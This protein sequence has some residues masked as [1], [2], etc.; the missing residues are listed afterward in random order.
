M[1]EILLKKFIQNKAQVIITAVFIGKFIG[2]YGECIILNS[3]YVDQK[4]KTAKS[5]NL[6]FIHEKSIK[7]IDVADSK[8]TLQDMFCTSKDVPLIKSFLSK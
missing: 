3:I 8:G 7:A 6:L 1:L 2:A 5:G 4:D